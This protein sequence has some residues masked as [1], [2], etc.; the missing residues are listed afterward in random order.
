MT[1]LAILSETPRSSQ[2]PHRPRAE[3]M[4]FP[5]LVAGLVVVMLSTLY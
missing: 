5:S 3:D 2:A 4:L 1:M